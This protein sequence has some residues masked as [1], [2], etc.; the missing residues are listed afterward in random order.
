MVYMSKANDSPEESRLA[1]FPDLAAYVATLRRYRVLS[2][3]FLIIGTV[4]GAV[5]AL[6]QKPVYRAEVVIAPA[7][8]A[9]SS[10]AMSRLTGQ[11]AGLAAL[12]G[13]GTGDGDDVERSIAVLSSASLAEAFIR[14]NGLLPVLFEH[15]WN[16]ATRTWVDSEGGA[17]TYWHAVEEFDQNVRKISRDLRS[18]IITVAIEWHDRRV[19]AHW[20]D[21]YVA[22]A[23]QEMRTRAMNEANAALKSLNRQL[24]ESEL[25]EMRNILYGLVESQVSKLTL[26]EAR[27]E[28]AFTILDPALVPDEDAY[29]R[30]RRFAI[31]FL[32]G[33]VGL[34]ISLVVVILREARAASPTE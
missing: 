13:I 14:Q 30:P 27:P 12:A 33:I 2:L 25:L 6:I 22:L 31:I 3:V 26:A 8:S 34:V 32:S 9:E 21:A 11:F 20:A 23:N 16:A 19:A 1:L 28:F 17:P 4:I 24:E 10:A 29:V 18:G 7:R 15:R 5:Y